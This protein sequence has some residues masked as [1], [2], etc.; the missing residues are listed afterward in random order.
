M[1]TTSISISSFGVIC[2]G[3]SIIFLAITCIMNSFQIGK[4]NKELTCLKSELDE[5][6]NKSENSE[7]NEK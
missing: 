7:S 6:A 1:T 3:L 5:I 4:L 2:Q